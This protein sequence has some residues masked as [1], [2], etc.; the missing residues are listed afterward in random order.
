M[1]EHCVATLTRT[2]KTPELDNKGNK[3][4][5]LYFLGKAF[6]GGENEVIMVICA[7]PDHSNTRSNICT[8]KEWHVNV[9]F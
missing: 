1:Q 6:F 4:V 3:F 8:D 9:N 2:D 5:L 7:W